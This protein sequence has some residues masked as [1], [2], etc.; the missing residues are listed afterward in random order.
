MRNDITGDVVNVNTDQPTD[1]QKATIWFK[2][3]KY[4]IFNVYNPPAN[5]LSLNLLTDTEYNRTI[6]A[7][8]FNGHSTSWGYS[9]T[10]QSG[11]TLED[12]CST[13]NFFIVQD[14]SSPPTLLH[15]AHNTLS[16]PDLTVL[17][18]DLL[19]KYS[20]Q[21][22]DGIG[23]DHRPILTTIEAPSKHH[24]E[25]RTAWNF[26]KAKWD[27]YKETTDK[28]LQEID[29]TDKDVNGLC[30]AITGALLK[31]ASQCIPR[32]CRKK[33]KPFWNSTLED[34]VK[35]RQMARKQLEANPTVEN[36]INYN[37]TSAVAKRSLKTAKKQKWE[38]T[39][40][41]L[42]L[43]K[44]GSKAWSLLNNLSGD[45]RKNPKPLTT[46]KGIIAEEQRKA[47]QFNRHFAAVNRA[48]KLTDQDKELLRNLKAKERAPQ[49]NLNIFEECFTL[50]ELE[51]A[52]KK[53]K[54]RKSPGPDKIHNEM[55]TNLGTVGM[56]V[57][58]NLINLTWSS[59]QIPDMWKLA[60]I[61]PILKKG[62]PEENPSSYRPIS[63]TSCLG[64]LAERMINNRLYW[65][66]ETSN[67]LN[68]HQAG[69]RAGNRTDD[70]LF[71]LSQ[72]VIDGFQD[73]D[74]LSTT[75][76]FVDLQQAYDRVWRK[77][78]LWKMLNVGIHGNLYRWIKH[79]LTDRLINTK[80]NNGISSKE[81][82]EEGLPQGS[83]LS[84]TLFLIFI[85]DLPE[86]LQTEKALY[87]D[88]LALWHTHKLP[89]FSATALNRDLQRLEAY[90]NRWK[91]KINCSK[92][93]YTIFTKSHKVAKQ[94]IR[95]MLEG[96]AIQREDNPVYLGVQL[97]RQLTLKQHA[98]N[99]KEK[100]TKRMQLLKRLA[101]T[102]WGADKNTLRQ[103]YIGYVR[104]LM[105]YNIGLQ[106]ICSKDTQDSLDKVQNQAVHYISGAMRSAP[107]AACEIHT[108]IEPLAL[109]REA[110]AIEM[111]ERYRR[112]PKDHPNRK[113]VDSWTPNN[114]IQKK[115]ILMVEN[116]LQLKHHLPGNREMECPI[117]R[118]NPP[119]KTTKKPVI[120][121]KLSSYVSKK[122][123]E[124]T[125]LFNIGQ[126][127]IDSYSEK[128]IHI[129]TDGSA[130]KGTSNAGY[131]IRIEYPSKNCDEFYNPCGAY[132]SN[133]EAEA[134]AI[135]AAIHHISQVFTLETEGTNNLVVF[136]DSKSV[137]QALESDKQNT[138]TTRSLLCAL[139]KFLNTFNVQLTL[140]WIPSHCN[141]PG[142]ERAD[143]LANKG[144]ACE[145]PN[146]PVSQ[147]TAKQIIK[148]NTR[149][150]WLDRWAMGST[151]RVVFQHMTRPNKHDPINDLCRR[152]QSIIFQL[153]TDHTR[154]NAH[155]NRIKPE[156]PPMC[157]LCDHPYET[158]KH[159]LFHCASLKDLRAKFLP[160]SPCL[161]N[162]LYSNTRQLRQT[163]SYYV[164]AFGRRAQAHMTTGSVK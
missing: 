9:D 67:I 18:S 31:A 92:T 126:K 43:T 116:E 129:Y 63:L 137:L 120:K 118:N 117:S 85:N 133:F 127:T 39:C 88:D 97:D 157:T 87:A 115:S 33:Y 13:T 161:E 5:N 147:A 82:L 90:C 36:K 73:E 124:P 64:K 142:N 112:K 12:A 45:K 25:R 152:E 128:W 61:K 109:R 104:S 132:C 51:K 135:E 154:L 22:T 138:T 48:S 140:Q 68:N 38:Q 150:E 93:T 3:C 71:R 110:A 72:R 76:V 163:C 148:T 156:H 79:F 102:A 50:S 91:M 162:T 52:M 98:R 149:Q 121:T 20:T 80:V 27:L 151:G 83:S 99:V 1:I 78:L 106:T 6:V 7:G 158:T 69:F 37:R 26:K 28:L 47:E 70:Q 32:G 40:A 8:D 144:S 155:L 74:K 125:E 114:R 2:G 108:D 46:E 134:L 103:L 77:G 139:D 136:S 53:L 130:F 66:L 19:H 35:K 44:D 57:I 160:P 23:S 56:Q 159:F 41:D 30:S 119:H 62:K 4:S 59:G 89:V 24:Y 105:E 17:S 145:Q 122:H 131:G 34:V 60:T 146:F 81:V 21:V 86:E 95:L 11:R 164:M 49:A 16:R 54:L 143:V 123:S 101:S 55:L 100:A 10:N 96:K 111:V 14:S 42:D 107:T 84:C 15:R 141:I 153:R 94:N 29:S 113:V 58:L 65:W 75:A